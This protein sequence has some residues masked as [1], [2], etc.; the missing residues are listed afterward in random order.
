VEVDEEWSVASV[1]A[2]VK[3]MRRPNGRPEQLRFYCVKWTGYETDPFHCG[4][5]LSQEDVKNLEPLDTCG[6]SVPPITNNDGAGV[7]KLVSS[8]K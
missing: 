3:M 8:V 4:C 5:W 6:P 7:K 1:L 2:E